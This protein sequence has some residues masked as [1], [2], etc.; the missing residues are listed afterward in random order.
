MTVIDPSSLRCKI[1]NSKFHHSIVPNKYD[2]KMQKENQ[3]ICSA[4]VRWRDIHNDHTTLI[5]S[6]ND[7]FLT[8]IVYGFLFG[9]Q[10]GTVS[11]YLLNSNE[12][13]KDS[14]F[15]LHT[16]RKDEDDKKQVLTKAKSYDLLDCD[17]LAV[18]NEFAAYLLK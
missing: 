17:I 9:K 11:Q 2:G 15:V 8:G 10:T 3:Y 16:P 14:E 18:R 7:N 6:I 5:T 4:S 12:Q 1:C 13:L